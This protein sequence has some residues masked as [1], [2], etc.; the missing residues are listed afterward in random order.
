VT[1]T[2][3][4][5]LAGVG[6]GFLMGGNIGRLA[7][8]PL[9]GQTALV[10]TLIAT[11][12]LQ[13]FGGAVLPTGAAVWVWCVTAAICAVLAALNGRRPG[14]ALVG[15]GL[16]LNL[17]VVLL[18]AGMPVAMG[19]IPQNA[20]T[21]ARVHEQIARSW[22]HIEAVSSTRLLFLADVVPVTWPPWQRG[23]I[24]LG[25][26]FLAIGAAQYIVTTMV[27]SSDD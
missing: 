7:T 23:L 12:L 26:A 14:M 6:L 18:N 10:M 27:R 17:L 19:N 3:T 16:A 8:A 9:V 22:L 11:Q 1:L 2:L 21:Q 13:L 5:V 24:S 15:L 4:A 20:V 25:D